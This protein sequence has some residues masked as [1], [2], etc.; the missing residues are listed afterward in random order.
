MNTTQYIRTYAKQEKDEIKRNGYF[1]LE[2]IDITRIKLTNPINKVIKT[3]QNGKIE[4]L[5][6][7]KIPIIYNL[8]D[9]GSD[10]NEYIPL[11]VGLKGCRSGYGVGVGTGSMSNKISVRVDL[12][13]IYVEDDEEIDCHYRDTLYKV[14][15]RM[16]ELLTEKSMAEK[17][18][19][20]KSSRP[21]KGVQYTANVTDIVQVSKMDSN[22]YRMYPSYWIPENMGPKKLIKGMSFYTVDGTEISPFKMVGIPFKGTFIISLSSLFSSGGDTF[23]IRNFPTLTFVE[24]ILDYQIKPDNVFNFVNSDRNQNDIKKDSRDVLDKLT[25]INIENNK[26]E[27]ESSEKVGFNDN[28]PKDDIKN[29]MI[30]DIMNDG[31]ND[32]EKES[33][34]LVNNDEDKDNGFGNDQR[35]RLLESTSNVE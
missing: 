32:D 16:H 7:V 2:D 34:N 4:D 19:L 10:H 29:T 9:N 33:E 18:G 25:K 20:K 28:K 35:R 11:R 26:H 27:E 1:P 15:D 5:N 22:D 3:N 23:K 17:I 24:N 21:G 14:N 13:K 6:T 30:Q 8:A 31:N 12:N